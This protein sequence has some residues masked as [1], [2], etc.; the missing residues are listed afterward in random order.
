MEAARGGLPWTRADCAAACSSNVEA[1]QVWPA[2]F[3]PN[4]RH[5]QLGRGAFRGIPKVDRK[6]YWTKRK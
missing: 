3:A 4:P 2:P 6:D 5:Y 1:T